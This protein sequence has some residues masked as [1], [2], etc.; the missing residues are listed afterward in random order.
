L[1]RTDDGVIFLQRRRD[2][3]VKLRI[4]PGINLLFEEKMQ[5]DLDGNSR[6]AT[7]KRLA[8]GFLFSIG[9]A[10][11][12]AT[13]A[14]SAPDAPTAHGAPA[15]G[16]TAHGAASDGAVPNGAPAHGAASNGAVT[17]GAA[18]NG[19]VANPYAP[20]PYAPKG[21]PSAAA[22]A[23]LAPVQKTDVQSQTAYERLLNNSG[24][25]V[26]WLWHGKRGPLKA[27]DENGV[28]KIEGKQSSADEGSVTLKG[29]VVSLYGDHFTFRGTI[30]ILD[31]PDKGRRCDRTGDYD[32]RI[33]G[34]RKYWRLKQMEACDGLTDYVDI[35]F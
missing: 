17:N 23:A 13:P 1:N 22:P 12:V 4:A 32:F 8:A 14:I 5:T 16:A 31:A 10:L 25:T 18:T 26:Q 29:E 24:V 2:G 9:V 7:G 3:I 21:S 6:I 28:I 35:Y 27:T 11:G 33:T 15:Q 34:S 20:N 30:L 19:T